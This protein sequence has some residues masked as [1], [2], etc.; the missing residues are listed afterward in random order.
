MAGLC[1]WG[2]L[3][4][5]QLHDRAHNGSMQPWKLPLQLRMQLVLQ[6]EEEQK[7]VLLQELELRVEKKQMVRSKDSFTYRQLMRTRMARVLEM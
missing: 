1:A 6:E 3:Q 5:M 7:K 4:Q 2:I